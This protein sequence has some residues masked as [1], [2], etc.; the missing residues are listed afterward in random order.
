MTAYNFIQLN[1]E[2][3]KEIIKLTNKIMSRKSNLPHLKSI[4]NQ[5]AKEGLF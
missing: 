5:L 3:Q 1:K 4:Q 2:E